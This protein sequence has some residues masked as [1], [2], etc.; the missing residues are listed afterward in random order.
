MAALLILVSAV[1]GQPV[2]EQS[3]GELLDSP[4]AWQFG[5]GLPLYRHVYEEPDVMKEKG[6]VLAPAITGFVRGNVNRL[7]LNL[8]FELARGSV[9]YS[10]FAQYYD[11]TVIPIGLSSIKDTFREVRFLGGATLA[12]LGDGTIMPFAGVGLRWWTDHAEKH[13]G[14]YLRESRYIYSPVGCQLQFPLR[15]GARFDLALE[16]DYFWKGRQK[17]R[18]SDANFGGPM[19]QQ[20]VLWDNATNNQSD[21]NGLRASATWTSRPAMLAGLRLRYAIRGFVRYW[22]IA[23]SDIQVINVTTRL[24][25]P[26][27]TQRWLVEVWEPK[28]NTLQFGMVFMLLSR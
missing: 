24:G 4:R 11:G 20:F 17:S 28:N 22:N 18:L 14:G 27:V 5:L 3:G 1:S 13:L 25:D 2:G 7:A 6:W 23:D 10:G 15:E 21:G 9:D 16:Y 8:E 12:G 26:P 19:D